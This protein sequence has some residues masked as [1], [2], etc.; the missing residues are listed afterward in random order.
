MMR[1]SQRLGGGRFDRPL[2]SSEPGVQ[3]GKVVVSDRAFNRNGLHL[4]VAAWSICGHVY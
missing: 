4:V 1:C 2:R 3:L